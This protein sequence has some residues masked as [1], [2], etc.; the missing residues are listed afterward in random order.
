MDLDV[1]DEPQPPVTTID[2]FV[3]NVWQDDAPW[4]QDITAK[5]IDDFTNSFV[6]DFENPRMNIYEI[7]DDM[8]LTNPNDLSRTQQA[9][10]LSINTSQQENPDEL[11]TAFHGTK[12][13]LTEETTGKAKEEAI[14]DRREQYTKLFLHADKV[15][16]SPLTRAIETA[17][18]SMEGHPALLSHGLILFSVIREIKRIGGLDTV[19]IAIGDAI[20][21]RVRSEVA[22]VLGAKRADELVSIPFDINDTNNPWW[23]DMASYDSEKE[24]QERVQEFLTFSR[25]CE[26]KIPVFVGHSL[27]FKAFYSR[28]ISDELLKNRKHLSEHLKKFRLSNASMMA[29]TVAY[30]DKENGMSD[31]VIIDA[32]LI[33]GG[34]FHGSLTI[35]EINAKSINIESIK[36]STS[37][38]SLSTKYTEKAKEFASF[39]AELSNEIK[40]NIQKD[41]KTTKDAFSKSMKKLSDKF[42]DFLDK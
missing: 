21:K 36:H 25:F 19:G 37:T 5:T 24:Q 22:M 7:D 13:N 26:S 35:D 20:E 16:S 4:D 40:A 1:F 3:S 23:T 41:L 39:S 9:A 15:Y 32:D 42:Y 31:A 10:F 8:L 38:T 33:F 2:P 14:D 11:I 34:G 6:G 18:L 28:R 29:V 27:F 12:I 30:L 17:L